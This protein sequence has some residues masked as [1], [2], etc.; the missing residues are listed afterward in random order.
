VIVL[1]TN[2]VSE[3]MRPA[4]AARVLEWLLGRPAL[5]IHTTVI[6]QAEIL[7]GI[8][9]LPAGRRRTALQRSADEMFSQDFADRVLEFG[10]DEAP[11]YARIASERRRAGRPISHPDAQIA[12][13]ARVHGAA[14]ATRNAADFSGCGIEVVDPWD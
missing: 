9:L 5:E 8:L 3:L 2:V 7:F 12:A 11:V 1:D 4:P 6:T 10:A 13:I 14:V